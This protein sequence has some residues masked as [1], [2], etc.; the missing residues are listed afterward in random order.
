ME[1]ESIEVPNIECPLRQ[2]HADHLRILYT[3]DVILATDYHAVDVYIAVREY[4]Q[5]H[6][7]LL[8]R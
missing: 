2:E 3:R 5:S 7:R 8:T 6:A 1:D 4:V